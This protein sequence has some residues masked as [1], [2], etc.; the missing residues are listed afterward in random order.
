MDSLVVAK[1]FEF[2]TSRSVTISLDVPQALNQQAS[3]SVCTGFIPGGDAF[4]VD[5][6]T[7]ALQG[8]MIDGVF[9]RQLEL[10]HEFN[11]VAA[12][13]WF[14]DS[15]LPPVYKE[16]YVDDKLAESDR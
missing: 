14:R 2:D 12:V 9:E 6:S 3:V 7:C 8:T 5:Y 15:S 10:T 1:D 4:D 16:I 13:V 11:S